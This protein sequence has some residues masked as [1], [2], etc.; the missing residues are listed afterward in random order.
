ML[1]RVWSRSIFELEAA[2]DV[3]G[4]GGAVV[5]LLDPVTGGGR[6]DDAVLEE[7][8]TAGDHPLGGGGVDRVGVVPQPGEQRLCPQP[9]LPAEQVGQLHALRVLIPLGPRLDARGA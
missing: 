8:V 7:G 5:P 4:L 6:R 2:A 9:G 1:P 3:W